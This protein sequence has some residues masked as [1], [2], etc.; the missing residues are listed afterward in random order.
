MGIRFLRGISLK[1]QLT[2]QSQSS[3][4]DEIRRHRSGVDILLVSDL[5]EVVLGVVVIRQRVPVQPLVEI[6]VSEVRWDGMLLGQLKW[7][8]RM[9]NPVG[10]RFQQNLLRIVRKPEGDEVEDMGGC[11]FVPLIGNGA[12]NG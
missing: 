2:N 3:G 7:N 12:W 1:R 4:G 5:L 11:F 6:L 8:G 10:S 9:V